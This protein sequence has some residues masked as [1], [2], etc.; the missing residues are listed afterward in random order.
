[1]SAGQRIVNIIGAGALALGGVGLGY[2]SAQ[3]AA[4]PEPDSPAP[5]P[6]NV[7]IVYEESGEAR[8]VDLT[9]GEGRDVPVGSVAEEW[10]HLEHDYS[11]E[12]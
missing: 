4:A 1:M 2:V 10:P 12:G 6:V 8:H 3:P 7:S 11:E 5:G 9:D